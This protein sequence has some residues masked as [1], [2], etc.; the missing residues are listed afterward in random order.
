M[1]IFYTILLQG[2]FINIILLLHAI[3]ISCLSCVQTIANLVQLTSV[4]RFGNFLLFGQLLKACGN[5]YFFVKLS[6]SFN[7]LVKSFLGNFYRHLAT[8]YWSH[9]LLDKNENKQKRGGDRP[10]SNKL[11]KLFKMKMSIA[12]DWQHSLNRP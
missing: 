1:N 6:K 3:L 12:A 5:N 11:F 7:F 2:A 10:T 9:W 4:T 8:F